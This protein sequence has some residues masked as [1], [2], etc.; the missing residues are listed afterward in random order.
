[1]L[2]RVSDER[3]DASAALAKAARDARAA[4]GDE[5][6]E[7][8]GETLGIVA[9]TAKKLGVPIGDNIKAMF[10]F[11]AESVLQPPPL[12]AVRRNLEVEPSLVEELDTLRPRFCT[13]NLGVG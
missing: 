9:T 8:L 12:T 5:A 7:Q 4:F 10:L 2:N 6:Q 11:P 13:A 1:V 3:A